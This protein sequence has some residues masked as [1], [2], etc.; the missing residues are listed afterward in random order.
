MGQNAR[1]VPFC[2]QKNTLER[3]W[4]DNDNNEWLS[5]DH[6]KTMTDYGQSLKDKGN[7]QRTIGRLWLIIFDC[8]LGI[9]LVLEDIQWGRNSG[10]WIRVQ[11]KY[12]SLIRRVSLKDN[13]DHWKTVDY[14]Q[15]LWRVMERQRQRQRQRLIIERLWRLLEIIK[16]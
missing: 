8:L 14:C 1:K 7:H 9:F 12:L 16:D 13:D 5:K 3:L 10:K 6:W 2:N 4:I 11:G 15:R